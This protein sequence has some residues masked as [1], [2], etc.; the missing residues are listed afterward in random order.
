MQKEVNKSERGSLAAKDVVRADS[1]LAAF[2][3]FFFCFF[4][5]QLMFRAIKF[6]LIICSETD[7]Q[8]NLFLP[9]SP[10]CLTADDWFLLCLMEGV[11]A[12]L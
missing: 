1:F 2:R 12:L 8:D 3:F 5:S 4:S 11:A 9:S 6:T 10:C 7:H